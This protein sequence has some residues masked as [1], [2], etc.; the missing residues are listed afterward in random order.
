MNRKDEHVKNAEAQYKI[1]HTDFDDLQFVHYSLSHQKTDK[2]FIAMRAF[3]RYFKTPFYINAMTGGSEWTKKINEQFATVARETDLVMATGSVSAAIKDP[4]LWDS[5]KIV[6]KV[7]PKGFVIAN[8]GADRTLGQAMRAIE[9]LEADALEIHLN[10]PQE[11]VMPEGDRDF[12]LY[13]EHIRTMVEE[14]DIPI[15][16]KEVGFGM[17][18]EFMQDLHQ[19]GVQIFDVSGNGGTNFVTIENE[20]RKAHEM[21]YLAQWGQSTAI[22]LLESQSLQ[23]EGVQIIASGGIKDPLQMAKAYA[24]G[25][26]MVGMSGQFLHKVLNEGIDATIQMVHDYEE[27]L[28]LIAAMLDVSAIRDLTKTDLVITGRVAEWCQRRRIPIDYFATR[29]RDYRE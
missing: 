22:S 16:I 29:R 7:N 8:I 20:R 14:I 28:R 23:A 1:Q 10:T 17:S 27:Q 3:R 25:A 4:T 15:I 11:I 9:T 13:E 19:M 2:I 6:R 5:F 18:E 24:L 21:N 26:S 12:H